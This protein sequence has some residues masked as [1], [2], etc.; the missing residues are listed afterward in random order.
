MFGNR[1]K[2]VLSD[3]IGPEQTGFLKCYIGENIRLILD[4]IRYCDKNDIQGAVIFLD[5]EKAFDMIDWN[6]MFDTLTYFNFGPYFK[7]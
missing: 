2:P 6:F 5:Y 4:L 7:N 3:L 1:L